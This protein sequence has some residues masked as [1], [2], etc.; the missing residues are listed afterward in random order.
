MDVWNSNELETLVD[1]FKRSLDKP[2]VYSYYKLQEID[3]DDASEQIYSK[4]IACQEKPQTQ[5]SKLTSPDIIIC[6]IERVD[7]GFFSSAYVNF[8][9]SLKETEFVVKRRVSDFIWLREGILK[10]F[11]VSIIPP[12]S[13]LENKPADN[14]YI[15]HQAEVFKEFLM[16][17]ITDEELNKSEFLE[18]FLVQPDPL[19]FTESKKTID[20]QYSKKDFKYSVSKKA[21]ESNN[22]NA[23]KL[24]NTKTSTKKIDLKISTNLKDFFRTFSSNLE[25]NRNHMTQLKELTI[26]LYESMRRTESVYQEMGRVCALIH[27]NSVEFNQ[28]NPIAENEVFDRIFFSLQNM[29]VLFGETSRKEAD[30]SR[31]NY[32]NLFRQWEREMTSLEEVK[33]D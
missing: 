23:L 10:E 27:Q 15:S 20:S 2:G 8:V 12:L 11:P 26:Q 30:V 7:G 22:G 17:I 21:V 31:F 13:Y 14:D 3:I 24:E 18:A 19:I 16:E 5:V 25:E 29:F 28:I 32:F 1:L 33:R 6:G 9:V 4:R